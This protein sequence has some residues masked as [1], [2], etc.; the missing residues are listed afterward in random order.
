ME[1][2]SHGDRR[3]GPELQLVMGGGA[4]VVLARGESAEK[5]MTALRPLLGEIAIAPVSIEDSRSRRR[6]SRS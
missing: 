1:R 3:E 4:L 5:V 2:V 6:P